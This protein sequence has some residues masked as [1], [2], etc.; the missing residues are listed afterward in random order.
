MAKTAVAAITVSDNLLQAPSVPR[1]SEYHGAALCPLLL[2]QGRIFVADTRDDFLAAAFRFELAPHSVGLILGRP[3]LSKEFNDRFTCAGFVH[4][5]TGGVV[6]PPIQDA[7]FRRALEDAVRE[8]PTV[9]WSHFD[10]SIRDKGTHWKNPKL[11]QSGF[12][13]HQLGGP[14]LATELFAEWR[15]LA[16]GLSRSGYELRFEGS[17]VVV[18]KH[19]PS[20]TVSPLLDKNHPEYF[21]RIIELGNFIGSAYFGSAVIH[22]APLVPKESLGTLVSEV[23]KHAP[24][25]AVFTIGPEGMIRVRTGY[26]SEGSSC[27]IEKLGTEDG[28]SAYMVYPGMPSGRSTVVIRTNG[29]AEINGRR[30]DLKVLQ[31]WEDPII[32]SR[33]SREGLLFARGSCTEGRFPDESGT[34][35]RFP[36][37]I[38]QDDYVPEGF[39]IVNGQR[40]GDRVFLSTVLKDRFINSDESRRALSGDRVSLVSPGVDEQRPEKTFTFTLP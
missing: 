7:K 32:G 34:Y 17:A 37:L 25:G 11:E 3:S 18:L 9:D 29:V 5:V 26:R 40:G 22:P 12:P 19:P 10:L 21:R 14:K 1:I 35:S 6:F 24:E 33:A 39:S 36:I 4:P 30:V 23:I 8:T 20:E 38:K 15:G 16:G 27:T 2:E 31:Q 13:C 28:E